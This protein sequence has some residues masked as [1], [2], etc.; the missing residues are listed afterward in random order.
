MRRLQQS[1]YDDHSSISQVIVYIFLGPQSLLFT[2]KE[3]QS[4]SFENF[5]F[6]L[7]GA[8]MAH[9]FFE[10]RLLAHLGLQA[11]LFGKKI[12][13]VVGRFPRPTTSP[14][15]LPEEAPQA[16]GPPQ[17]ATLQKALRK[18]QDHMPIF[19]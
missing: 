12:G 10:R 6:I 8:P 9:E 15:F 14:I 17:K 18:R 4:F 16:Q 2:G 11:S 13:E 1:N 19:A 5:G 3:G 7:G